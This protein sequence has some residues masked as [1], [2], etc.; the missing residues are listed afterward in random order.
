[1]Y[2]LWNPLKKEIFYVGKGTFR[3]GYRRLSEHMKDTRRYKQGKLKKTYKFTTISSILD[4][5]LI[6][7]IRIVFESNDEQS[8]RDKEIELINFYGRRDINTGILVNHTNGGEGML[9]YKHTKEHR[10]KLKID[11]KGGI[12]T[13]IIVHSISPTTGLIVKTF[14]S[15][16]QAAIILTGKNSSKS[17]IQ[18]AAT[19]HL[20]R[21]PYGFYWRTIENYNPSEDV[22]TYNKY[23]VDLSRRSSKRISQYSLDNELIT[24]WNSATEICIHYNNCVSALQKYL[25]SGK[26]WKGYFWKYAS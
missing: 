25:K 2:E 22:R 24:T 1:M 16:Q 21:C 11:N 15:F 7:E 6:P 10:D 8:V 3:N 4:A 14:E 26:S 20:K 9:G 18:K 12:A 19:T 5:G 13:A 23:R 17:N